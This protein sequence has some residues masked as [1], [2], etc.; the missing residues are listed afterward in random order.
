[1]RLPFVFLLLLLIAISQRF[2]DP[3][4]ELTSLREFRTDVAAAYGRFA[5][6]VPVYRQQFDRKIAEA[7]ISLEQEIKPFRQTVEK[8]PREIHQTYINLA[9]NWGVQGIALERQLHEV[10][11]NSSE[12]SL[13]PKPFAPDS[14]TDSKEFHGRVGPHE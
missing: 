10:N 4:S 12:A 8:M 6:R 11:R 7:L 9:S 13:T 14:L 1:M 3:A 5:A 2:P